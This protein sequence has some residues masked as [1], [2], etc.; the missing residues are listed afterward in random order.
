MLINYVFID[1]LRFVLNRYFLIFYLSQ[2][3]ET[4][5]HYIEK[6]K[7]FFYEHF[8]KNAFR[9]VAKGSKGIYIEF[10]PTRFFPK[11]TMDIFTD[12]N[13]QGI[14]EHNLLYIFDELGFLEM[15]NESP[16]IFGNITRLHLT[17]NFIVEEPVREYTSV[18][19][20]RNCNKFKVTEFETFGISVATQ[21]R[22]KEKDATT[23]KRQTVLYDKPEEIENKKN[24]DEIVLKYPL[25]DNEKTL[26]PKICISKKG[27]YDCLTNISNLKMLR[28]EIQY[29]SND[30]MKKLAEN[31]QQKDKNL[32]ISTLVKLLKSETLYNNLN[33]Y[34]TCQLKESIFTINPYDEP[35]MSKLTQYD[36]LFIDLHNETKTNIKELQALYNDYRKDSIAKRAIKK[37][38]P[39]IDNPLYNELYGNVIIN[40]NTK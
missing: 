35:D 16:K 39:Y 5:E 4:L 32:K 10:N 2:K 3:D 11:N 19:A 14:S 23:M 17:K 33:D 38:I 29:N 9:I 8:P 40:C 1:K 30:K 18:I 21:K 13:I 24:I 20:Q 15:L 27:N 26:I 36:K 31:L 25:T 12:V 34:Y 22:N 37:L 28:V 6:V 7:Q